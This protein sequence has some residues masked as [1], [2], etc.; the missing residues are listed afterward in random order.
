MMSL[1]IKQNVSLAGYTSFKCGGSAEHLVEI[2]SA[3]ELEQFINNNDM[4]PI[5]TIGYG[6]N[7]LI[8]DRGIPGLV[9]VT[10]GGKINIDSGLLVADSGVWW[11]NAVKQSIEAGLWGIELMSGIPGGVGAAVAGNIA[12]YGQAVADNLEYT[13]VIDYKSKERTRLG[14][15]ELNMTYRSSAFNRGELDTKVILRAAF[16]LS[17]S[18]TKELKYQTALD[19]ASQ[20]NLDPDSLKDR[21]KIIMLAR[22]KAGSLLD[23]RSTAGQAKTA[24]SFFR[25]PTLSKEQ[26]EQIVAFDETG[27]TAEQITKMNIEHGGDSLRVSAAHVMLAA[28][29][30]RGQSWGPVRLHPDHV[31]KIE[32]TGNATSQQIYEVVQEIITTVKQKLG[33]DLIPEVRF[34][35]KF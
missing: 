18:Q 15:H 27:R 35:G 12:A 23:S 10:N 5:L 7:S 19:E 26:A 14:T 6:T 8:S 29:F 31:L 30:K 28:G 17:K 34:L 4:S 9:I 24:G 2:K 1:Q 20:N 16:K 32:N 22:D 25:N 33:I 11:D 21:R 3:D 13:D